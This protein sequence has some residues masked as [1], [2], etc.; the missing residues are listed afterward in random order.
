[1]TSSLFKWAWIFG[2]WDGVWVIF[3]FFKSHHYWMFLLMPFLLSNTICYCNL[4]ENWFKI[5]GYCD[6]L[7]SSCTEHRMM[8][9]LLD[10]RPNWSCSPIIFVLDNWHFPYTVIMFILQ[11][12]LANLTSNA[13]W[14]MIHLEF[15][16]WILQGN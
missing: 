8:V 5:P 10:S 14:C 13:T 1:M 16:L 9:I 3:E 15:C 4:V 11:L 12:I 6:I 2:Y 7:H